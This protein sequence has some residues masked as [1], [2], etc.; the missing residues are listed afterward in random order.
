M[1]GCRAFIPS[2]PPTFGVTHAAAGLEDDRREKRARR[3]EAE[4]AAAQASGVGIAARLGGGYS[5]I[6]QA[7]SAW[8]TPT[9]EPEGIYDPVSCKC[10]CL[11]VF[12]LRLS[13]AQNVI[14]WDKHTIVGTSKK[15]EKP[16]L[17]LTSVRPVER[18][19]P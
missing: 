18:R 12:R 3:F 5:R 17:R 14:D 9:P 4:R 2:T 10:G 8:D 1:P 16:F 13:C 11:R 19:R 6:V 7:G 15:L